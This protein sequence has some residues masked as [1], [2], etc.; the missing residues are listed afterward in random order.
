MIVSVN[1]KVTRPAAITEQM[2]IVV[3]NRF[4]RTGIGFHIFAIDG[5]R[6]VDED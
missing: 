6:V 5:A 1:T 4:E 2:I 3:H